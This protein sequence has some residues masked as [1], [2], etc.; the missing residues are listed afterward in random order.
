MKRIKQTCTPYTGTWTL[1][2]Q[3]DILYLL[4]PYLKRRPGYDQVMTGYGAKTKTGLLNSL[5]AI[6]LKGERQ[7]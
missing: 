4:W 6:V 3:H 1:A 7:S 2:Q 5:E